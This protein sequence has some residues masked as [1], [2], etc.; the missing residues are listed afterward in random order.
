MDAIARASGAI[1]YGIIEPNAYVGPDGEIRTP[2]EQ[3]KP[4]E[5]VSQLQIY[6]GRYQTCRSDIRL[7]TTSYQASK[8]KGSTR[9]MASTRR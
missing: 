6:T 3:G 2:R 7:C 5:Y 9:K 1:F 4:A 8:A